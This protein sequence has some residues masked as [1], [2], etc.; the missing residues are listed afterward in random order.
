MR[1]RHNKFVRF[2]LEFSQ[3]ML[4]F[5][6]VFSAIMCTSTSLELTYD[7]VLVAL[8]MF[9]ASLVF[10]ALFTVLETFRKG[11]MYGILW[12]T[13]FFVVIGIRFSDAMKKAFVTLANSFLKEFMTN[14]GANLSLLSYTDTDGSNLKF[15]TNLLLILVGVYLIAI[16]SAFF[17]RRRRSKVFVMA[18]AP[19]VLLPLIVGKIGFYSDFFIYLIVAMTIVGTRHLRTDA[20]DRRMRQKLAIILMVL[21]LICGGISYAIVP[22][23]KY[24]DNQDKIEEAKNSIAKLTTWS[25]EDVF[26][27]LKSNFND[28]SMSYGEIGQKDTISYTGETLLKVS[29][30]V[31][32]QHGMYL[33]G[34]VGDY[35]ENNKWYSFDDDEE[36]YQQSLKALDD[37]GISL[38][39][40]HAQLRNE[41]GD[42]ERSGVE[43]F[44]QTGK[45]HVRNLAFGYGNYLVPYLPTTAFEQKRNGRSSVENPGIDYT[46]EYYLNYPVFMRQDA[47]SVVNNLANSPFWTTNEAERK[48]LKDFAEKY[49]LSI[50][51]NLQTLCAQFR[52]SV[53]ETKR[54]RIIR[55]VKSYITKDTS[56]T[57]SPGKTPEGRDTVEYFLTES[58]KAYCSYYASAAAILLR[59]VGIPTRYVEGVYVPKENIQKAVETGGEIQVKDEDLHA[60]IEVFDERYGFVP[61]EV[62]PGRGEEDMTVHNEQSNNPENNDSSEPSNAD[63]PNAQ[64]PEDSLEVSTPTPSAT[65]IP[66]E[67]MTFEDI[68]GNE[69]KESDEKQNTDKATQ[70]PSSQKVVT[71]LIYAIIVLILFMLVMEVQR[72]IR[73]RL[74]I[75]NMKKTKAKKRIRMAY[76]HLVPIFAKHSVVYRG[77]SMAEFTKEIAGAFGLLE[78]DI[79][80]FVEM[81]Y[82]AR[83]G[84]DDITEEQLRA[85]GD[86]YHRIR[87]TAYDE[88]K[89]FKK[90]YYMYIKVL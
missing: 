88:M 53:D 43:N 11:K 8:V 12:I 19:F 29:G 14:T 37:T 50:P 72:R 60:W 22:P 18:T 38:D 73:K 61:V 35:Y 80:V 36:E 27:W 21:G 75:R 62:T 77:Q 25:A 44:W 79:A 6:G 78:K 51:D 28:D 2:I 83:F 57:L 42:D 85:F 39:N 74:F 31:N 16:V 68:E 87:N 55:L 84:P 49:Y 52:G 4:V 48:R 10:Y 59:S 3:I 86:I 56:Y 65:Q 30:E 46:T 20:T 32:Q 15:C 45:L 23:K 69:D 24:Y 9:L 82:H 64:S 33:K 90:I 41:L 81:V 13:L 5:L 17:Y 40:W 47:F 89:M 67:S 70:K 71:I 66:E 76:H 58:K 34:Y 26:T 7:E 63:S 1:T 54:K